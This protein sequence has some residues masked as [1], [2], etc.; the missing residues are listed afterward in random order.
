MKKSEFLEKKGVLYEQLRKVNTLKIKELLKYYFHLKR[1][2]K[3][4]S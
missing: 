3:H 4:F 1:T 2:E